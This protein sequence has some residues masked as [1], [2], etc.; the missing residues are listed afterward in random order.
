MTDWYCFDARQTIN[1]P[2][3][4]N[5]FNTKSTVLSRGITYG[6]NT[7][8]LPTHPAPSDRYCLHFDLE[9]GSPQ[10]YQKIAQGILN[11]LKKPEFIEM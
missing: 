5:V 2:D 11:L 8:T 1:K 4:P 9:T 10:E 3:A 7:R 6:I